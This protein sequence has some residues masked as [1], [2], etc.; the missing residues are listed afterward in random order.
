MRSNLTWVVLMDKW[1]IVVIGWGIVGS[2]L[3]IAASYVLS[4]DRANSL[5]DLAVSRASIEVSCASYLGWLLQR[6]PRRPLFQAQ[7][8]VVR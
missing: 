3:A 1:L 4:W 5:G 8:V 7:R 6:L 2:V